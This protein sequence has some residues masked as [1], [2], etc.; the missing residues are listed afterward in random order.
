MANETPV[1][2]RDSC[3]TAHCNELCPEEI[4]FELSDSHLWENRYENFVYCIVGVVTLVCIILKGIF[5]I[6]HKWLLRN[7][8]LFLERNS[9]ERSSKEIEA[10]ITTTF[11]V[12]TIGIIA[13]TI[14]IYLSLI[15]HYVRPYTKL[16]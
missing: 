1:E 16:I 4:N 12:R 7:Q 10:G 13:E 3:Y 5:F 15:F 14:I 6:W 8:E 9:K 11:Q 2:F